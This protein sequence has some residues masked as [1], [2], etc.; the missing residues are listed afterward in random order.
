MH[1]LFHVGVVFAM[2]HNPYVLML[3]LPAYVLYLL[4]NVLRCW[5]CWR[6][7]ALKVKDV[8]SI[9]ISQGT[10]ILPEVS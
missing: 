6:F 5:R 8:Q 9:T 4:D 7:K 2:L 10:G 1:A 3:V